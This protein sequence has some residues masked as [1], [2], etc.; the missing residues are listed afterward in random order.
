M[1]GPG[2]EAGAGTSLPSTTNTIG[3]PGL[4]TIGNSIRGPAFVPVSVGDLTTFVKRFGNIS[5]DSFG[6]LAAQAWLDHTSGCTY[7][8]LLGVGNGKK[9]IKADSTNSDGEQIPAGAVTNSGFVV[10]SRMTG[11][12]GFLE[13]NPFATNSGLPGRT[14]FLGTFMSESA[15]S[16]Y[17]SEAGLQNSTTAAPILRGVLF[18]ASGVLP[19][20][21]GCYSENASTASIGPTVGSFVS[22]QDGGSTVGSV[23]LSA[24]SDRFV[25]LL[26]GH[27]DT[28][29][30]PNTITASFNSQ[31]TDADGVSLFFANTLNTD[32]AKI[33][34]AGHYLY[35]YFD[36]PHSRAVITGSGIVTAGAAKTDTAGDTLEESAFLL[37]SSLQRNVTDAAGSLAIPNFENFCDRFTTANT[38][39]LITQYID[40]KQ[41]NLFRFHAIDDGVFGSNQIKITISNIEQQ[42]NDDEYGSFDITVRS[43]DNTDGVIT[44]LSGS[45]KFVGCNLDPSSDSYI[46]KVI[47][48]RHFY[49]NFEANIDRQKFVRAGDYENRSGIIRVEV[50]SKVKNQT[51]PSR[52]LPVGFRGPKHLIVSGSSILSNPQHPLLD[53]SVIAATTEWGN[54]VNEPPIPYR[55]MIAQNV[56]SP[57]GMWTNE[58]QLESDMCWG[59]QTTNYQTIKQPN[60]NLNFNDSIKSY[61]KY[62]PDFT[63]VRQKAFVGDNQ[64]TANSAGTVYD[65]DKY[66]NNKFSL[67]NILIHTRSKTE[68][69]VDNTQWAYAK[70]CRDRIVVPL[71]NSS[72]HKKTGVRFFDVKKD[73]SSESKTFAK[74]TL[75][76]QGGFDG[77]SIF[78]KEKQKF[79]NLSAYYEMTDHTQGAKAGSTCGAY[80]SAL[81]MMNEESEA[82]IRLLALPGVRI[83]AITNHALSV[84]ENRFDAFY[85]M[86][87]QQIASGSGNIVTGS[88]DVSPSLTAQN[89]RSR[90]LNSSYAGVYFPD[91]SMVD[92]GNATKIVFAPPSVSA[93]RVYARMDSEQNIFAPAGTKRGLIAD[94][95][96]GTA[97]EAKVKFDDTQKQTIKTLYDVAINPIIGSD[98]GLILFGQRTLLTTA[99][100]MLQRI[101]VRRMVL[102][103]RRQCRSAAKSVLFE[104]NKEKTLKAFENLL[105]PILVRMA[106]AGGVKKY[107]VKV[108]TSS[109]TQADIE[110]NVV[111]GQVFIQPS[112][113]DEIIQVDFST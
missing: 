22:K 47:G 70:Y 55:E 58:K 44:A 63:T 10:G 84:A 54:R 2:T 102:E 60:I 61:M 113:S 5:G 12:N 105:I 71:F 101:S 1:V 80:F 37:T 108:D 69:I 28:S 11:S 23:N 87:I 68:D 6:T 40:R 91:V 90:A 21:S 78:S 4:G 20:L 62:F 46:A 104:Q 14:Y 27:K 51:L 45:E 86:D 92:P 24:G 73:L 98:S 107:K 66:N 95:S 15:G 79:S 26:N 74:Y 30:H 19:A 81:R 48:D 33:R 96:A 16:T 88:E 50:A 43:L 59:V 8:R 36:I 76:L 18:A 3:A 57:T 100:S 99:D 93:V 49:F 89:F 72:L 110:A 42:E 17:L 109:T 85:V 25:L 82:D 111:R 52:I 9:R 112:R 32:P 39:W 75:F 64:G 106:A 13:S 41:H 38:P 83:E 35:N 94:V 67:E 97:V 103:I 53:G 7:I 31:A 29:D 77:N 65:C 34:E 56:K